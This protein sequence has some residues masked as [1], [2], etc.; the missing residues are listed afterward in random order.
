MQPATAATPPHWD[1]TLTEVTISIDS[2]FLTSAVWPVTIEPNINY[3]L[4]S[5]GTDFPMTWH[6]THDYSAAEPK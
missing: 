5:S 4:Q 2:S 6:P 3:T 1:L